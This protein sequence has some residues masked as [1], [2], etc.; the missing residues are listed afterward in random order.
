MNPNLSP[1][2]E[3]IV[4]RCLE[5]RVEARFQSTRDL[6]FA[7]RTIPPGLGSAPITQQVKHPR[8]LRRLV[9]IVGPV[10]LVLVGILGVWSIRIKRA[11]ETPPADPQPVIT[12]LTANPSEMW[13]HAAAISP[14][15]K[16][17]A[18]EDNRG[19]HRRDVDSGDTQL[20]HDSS[21]KRLVGWT[22]DSSR[23]RAASWDHERAISWEISVLGPVIQRVPPFLQGTDEISWRWP[24]WNDQLVVLFDSETI[25][26]QRPDG[27]ENKL[28]VTC[29]DKGC[30]FW[31]RCWWSA[32]SKRLLFGE[33]DSKGQSAIK[34]VSAD[35]GPETT[36]L[37][38]GDRRL[39]DGGVA[40]PDAR[41]LGVIA[42]SERNENIWEMW[43]NPT[44][45]TL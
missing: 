1:A 40:L 11:L 4:R 44:T 14:D 35:G 7:L 45:W 29:K 24:S 33:I 21:E 32:D 28:L 31:G 39:G 2:I 9:T 34:T 37:Q 30:A 16:Y 25:A 17:V 26:V 27:S 8:P 3:R 36:V 10:A 20:L 23:V 22:R 12:R 41:L 13:V 42:E 6:A 18:Y 38:V 43:L 15:G 5:K 19:I